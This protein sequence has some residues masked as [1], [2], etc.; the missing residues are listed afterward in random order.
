MQVVGSSSEA[1]ELSA[2]LKNNLLQM[3][4]ISEE[5]GKEL[6][7]LSATFRDEGFEEMQT[8]VKEILTA[9]YGSIED[10][11]SVCKALNRYADILDE[12]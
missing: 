4:N 5:Q 7:K 11:A 1:R 8:I 12:R 2:R 3:K 6:E 9:M 10:I